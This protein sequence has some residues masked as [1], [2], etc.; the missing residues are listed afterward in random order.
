M[1]PTKT[2]GEISDMRAAGAIL[3]AVLKELAAETRIGVSLREL[4]AKAYRLIRERGAEPA[5][6]GY[7]PYGAARPFPTTL[8]ASLNDVVVHGVPTER[9]LR[10]GD[11][12]KLD[13]GVRKNGYYA[14]GALTLTLGVVPP[15]VHALVRATAGAL[16]A[17][18]R[19]CRNGRTLGDI[20]AAMYAVVSRAGFHVVRGLTGH[21]IGRAL[22]EE[23]SVHTTGKPGAGMKIKTGHVFAL[24]VMTGLTSGEL[25]Q[26]KDESYA[27]ADGSIAAHFEHTVLATEHGPEILTMAD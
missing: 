20:G 21:G 22:H 12:I 13:L 14:D 16:W 24:E 5:F 3:A 8:C 11:V 25:V 27:I 15:A 1:V 18:I 26:Q 19:N 6:K 4:D 17:G 7:Q 10:N 23:P 9:I 2:A